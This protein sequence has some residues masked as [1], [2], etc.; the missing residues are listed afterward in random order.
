MIECFIEFLEASGYTRI[1]NLLE[2]LSFTSCGGTSSSKSTSNV[3]AVFGF[4]V[5]SHGTFSSIFKWRNTFLN[6]GC[7]LVDLIGW[8]AGDSLLKLAASIKRRL[9]GR[10]GWTTVPQRRTCVWRRGI[11]SSFL[12]RWH[13]WL[14][15]EDSH[16]D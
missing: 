13:R 14:Q 7:L 4:A 9:L 2:R 16:C 3:N 1:S 10:L 5:S 8:R 11:E 12:H 15:V 6:A